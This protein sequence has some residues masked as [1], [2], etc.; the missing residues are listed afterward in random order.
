MRTKNDLSILARPAGSADVVAERRHRWCEYANCT[1]SGADRITSGLCDWTV[2]I[3][4]RE[5][6]GDPLLSMF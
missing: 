3:L 5:L 2:I 1:S 4:T 6:H